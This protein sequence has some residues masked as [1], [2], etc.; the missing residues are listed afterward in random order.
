MEQ[1]SLILA[2]PRGFCNGVIHAIKAVEEA[3]ARYGAPV[4]VLHEIV[5]NLHVCNNLKA[6]GARFI[7]EIDHIPCGAHAI[8]SAHGV[9]KE[10]E[11]QARK[12][13]LRI[14]D[15]TCSLVKIVH[16][17]AQAYSRNGL[18][19]IIIGNPGH[20]EIEGTKGRVEGPVHVL[21]TLTEVR[22]LKVKTP[23]RLAYVTQTT[24]GVEVTMQVIHALKSRFPAIQ[25][26]ELSNICFATQ[27][28]QNTIRRMA[29]EVDALLVVGSKNSSNSNRLRETGEKYGLRSYLIEDAGQINFQELKSVPRIGLTAGASA[30]E[31]LVQGVVDAL[32]GIYNLTV[33][34]MEPESEKFKSGGLEHVSNPRHESTDASFYQPIPV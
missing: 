24:Q 2:R 11:N 32:S 1:K 21:S 9:S 18:E 15:A 4:Y 10:I 25:G 20:A 5:H 34:E 6:M 27:S 30:P 22:N 16:R 7:D 17:D 33:R 26:P 3:L 19:V 14:I 31:Y 23:D 12:R 13:H 8:F 28:R 29:T